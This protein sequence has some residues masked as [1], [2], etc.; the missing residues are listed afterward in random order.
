M[1]PAD[2]RS[3]S[4]LVQFELLARLFCGPGSSILH[5]LTPTWF[6]ELLAERVAEGGEVRARKPPRMWEGRC[7][8]TRAGLALQDASKRISCTTSRSAAQ[9]RVL[10]AK[11]FVN[12]APNH[13]SRFLCYNATFAA[14]APSTLSWYLCASSCLDGWCEPV[15]RH[16]CTT[17]QNDDTSLSLGPGRTTDRSRQS[18]RLPDGRPSPTLIPFE[19]NTHGQ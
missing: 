16:A 7:R 11:T 18:H 10:V 8:T 17:L 9:H 13:A 6:S 3:L 15:A 12:E 19:P 2:S 14:C 4:T 1:A 5:H